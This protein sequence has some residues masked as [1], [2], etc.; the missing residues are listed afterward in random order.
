MLHKVLKKQKNSS[1]CFICGI[2]NDMGVKAQFYELD[3][4]ELVALC[5]INEEMQ[6]YPQR[7]HGGISA[8][9]LDEVIG[10]AIMID[11]PDAW[12]VTAE[13]NLKYKKP[14]PLNTP[15]KVVARITRL[16]RLIFEG[17]GEIILPDGEI[18]VTA[19]G[20][21]MRVP[22]EKISEIHPEDLMIDYINPDD[23]KEI[24]I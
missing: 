9:L 23:P 11:C 20:K 6:S 4:K 10:R 14:V 18:A 5:N 15:L 13:L 8:A 17:T 21:Y 2:D 12:G 7:V 3:N 1:M 24:D 19:S 22:L 16:T